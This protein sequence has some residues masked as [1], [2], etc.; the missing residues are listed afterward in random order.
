[1]SVIHKIVTATR[2][3]EDFRY[4]LCA[5][6]R[7]NST[8]QNNADWESYTTSRWVNVT[9]GVCLGMHG[10]KRKFR[11]LHAGGNAE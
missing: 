3:N 4:Q 8:T 9:C 1:M 11:V 7:V 6:V 5:A 10:L 2:K